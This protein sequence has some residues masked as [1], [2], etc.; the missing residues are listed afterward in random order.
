MRPVHLKRG[1]F[2]EK[3]CTL[4][5]FT[6]LSQK[7]PTGT[8]CSFDL[9][10]ILKK[11]LPYYLRHKHALN[12]LNVLSIRELIHSKLPGV[13]IKSAS[14][15]YTLWTVYVLC[16]MKH[17]SCLYSMCMHVIGGH[18][19]PKEYSSLLSNYPRSM[20]LITNAS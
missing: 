4:C 8:L 10:N 15:S 7:L 11:A 1:H 19:Q 13:C 18:R 17:V 12:S 14:E 2:G 20:Y 3:N 6:M 5:R 16:L 9:C